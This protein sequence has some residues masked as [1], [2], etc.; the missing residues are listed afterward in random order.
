MEALSIRDLR[1]RPGAV[2]ADLAKKR[3]LL[4]TPNGRPVALTLQVDDSSLDDTLQAIRLV[5]R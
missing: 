3:E 5:R 4:L 1:N 2:Q